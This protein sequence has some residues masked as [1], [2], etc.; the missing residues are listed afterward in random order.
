MCHPAIM[1]TKK[2]SK[3]PPAMQAKAEAMKASKGK[4][5]KAPKKGS[6]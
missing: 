1:P 2:M 6:K 3:L 5:T 4:S